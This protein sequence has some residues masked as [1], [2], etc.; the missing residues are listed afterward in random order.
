MGEELY[1]EAVSLYWTWQ[2]ILSSLGWFFLFHLLRYKGLEVHISILL[3]TLLIFYHPFPPASPP[4][5]WCTQI[6]EGECTMELSAVLYC[7]LPYF[8]RHR[9][10]VRLKFNILAR[11]H[12]HQSPRMSHFLTSNSGVRSKCDHTQLFKVSIG[13]LKPILHAFTEW[14]LFSKLLPAPVASLM[15]FALVTGSLGCSTVSTL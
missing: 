4:P 6:Y 14:V 11:L 13:D 3:M 5:L 10:V 12:G 15:E 1:L 8:F 7:N 2:A 9:L